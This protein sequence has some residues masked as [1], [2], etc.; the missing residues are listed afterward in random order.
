M[1]SNFS[2]G[3]GDP[4]WGTERHLFPTITS[5]I[6][7]NAIGS[8]AYFKSAELNGIFQALL[9]HN[10]DIITGTRW[11]RHLMP[12]YNLHILQKAGSTECFHTKPCRSS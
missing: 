6:Y 1:E 11:S 2:D 5:E 9:L 12:A 7:K 8:F 4:D 10:S 3:M